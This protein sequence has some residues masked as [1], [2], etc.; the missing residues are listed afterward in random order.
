LAQSPAENR[1]QA[2]ATLVWMPRVRARIAAGELGGE[3]EERGAAG[4]VGP[5]PEL[6]QALGAG[7]QLAE[8]ITRTS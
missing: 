3:P 7:N 4:L 6:V 2:T 8:L 1:C 5:D